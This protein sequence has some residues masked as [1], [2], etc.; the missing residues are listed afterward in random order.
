MLV[1]YLQI[2]GHFQTLLEGVVANPDQ[3]ISTLPLLSAAQEQQLL[4]K[5][6][7][8]QVEDPLDKCIHQLFEEQV[9]K[10]P[11]V[12][13]AVFE[14]EQLTYWELNQRANQLAHYLG[15]L[16][17]G[18]DTLVGICVERSLE[19][20]VGLLGILKAGGAYVPLDPTYPQ[21]RLAFMLSDAQVSLLVTQEKLVTQLPQH[22][23]DVVSLDRDWTVISSQSEEN[24][25]PVSDATAEN[26][27]YAIYTSGSTGK[28]K[29]VLV[30]HQ[31]LVHSTQ[32]RIEYYSEPLTSYLLLSSDTF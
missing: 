25:N 27:A 7:D 30:T 5:W 12:V 17:V 11:E 13:A 31:N 1:L 10:T 15:S 2:L 8:T 20:L 32:A 24:Q 26:L 19:M 4:V 29:G 16:G 23:A 18:A 3:C 22:G 6:N 28:P 21:E 9:E 14:G